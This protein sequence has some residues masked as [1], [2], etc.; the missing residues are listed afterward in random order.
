M[1]LFS[2]EQFPQGKDDWFRLRLGR[3]T[4]SEFGSILTPAKGQKS[5]SQRPYAARCVDERVTGG[6]TDVKDTYMTKD[7]ERGVMRENE[8]ACRFEHETGYYTRKVGFCTTDDGRFGASPDRLVYLYDQ[9]PEPFAVLEIKNYNAVDHFAWAEENVLPNDFK[10]QVH[11][12]MIVTGLKTAYWMN[13]CPPYDPVIVRVD[14]DDFTNKL[15]YHLNEFDLTVFKPLLAKVCENGAIRRDVEKFDREYAA[16][17]QMA[18][19]SMRQVPPTPTE[20]G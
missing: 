8:A 18:K 16:L 9:V 13:N 6:P 15:A 12:E 3:P 14:W 17:L 19:R 2:H 11:G 4:A 1:I 5:A 7:M 20:V 10:C